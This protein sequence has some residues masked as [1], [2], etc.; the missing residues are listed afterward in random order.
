MSTAIVI[1]EFFSKDECFEIVSKYKKKYHKMLKKRF[2]TC[3][4]NI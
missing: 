4:G 3:M 2:K 1:P